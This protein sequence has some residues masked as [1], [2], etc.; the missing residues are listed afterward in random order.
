MYEQVKFQLVFRMAPNLQPGKRPTYKGAPMYI[1][2]LKCNYCDGS[3]NVLN[4]QNSVLS[5]KCT[6]CGHISNPKPIDFSHNLVYSKFANKKVEVQ[7]S[8]KKPRSGEYRRVS[9]LNDKEL[10]PDRKQFVK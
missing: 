9:S 6:K 2:G 1:F 7:Y 8:A 3:L 10:Y 4:M 5:T